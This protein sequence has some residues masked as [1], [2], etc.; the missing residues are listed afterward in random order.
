MRQTRKCCRARFSRMWRGKPGGCYY[1]MWQGVVRE[2]FT[3]PGLEGTWNECR[4]KAEESSGNSKYK[5]EARCCGL[6]YWRSGKG[7]QCR[8]SHEWRGQDG[9]S[10][11]GL[12]D[13]GDQRAWV[14]PLSEIKSQWRVL[15]RGTRFNLWSGCLVETSRHRQNQEPNLERDG[16][17]RT[18]AE[19][20]KVEGSSKKLAILWG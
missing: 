11:W 16:V 2:G 15:S 18:R 17:V 9:K 6:C 14:F 3:S 10:K 20:V 19:V 5:T 1:C 13:I 4:G 7:G 12:G 8:W